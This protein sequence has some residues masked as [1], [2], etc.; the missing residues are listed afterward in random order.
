METPPFPVTFGIEL[1]LVLLPKTDVIRRTLEHDDEL[2]GLFN[3]CCREVHRERT[4]ETKA[5]AKE[6]AQFIA[7]FAEIVLRGT[8]IAVKWADS[9]AAKEANEVGKYYDWWTVVDEIAISVDE[10]KAEWSVEIVSLPFALADNW[11]SQI[12]AVWSFVAKNFTIVNDQRGSTHCHM[13]QVPLHKDQEAQTALAFARQ[14]SK[15]LVVWEPCLYVCAPIWR[16][17]RYFVKSNLVGSEP[18]WQYLQSSVGFRYREVFEMLDKFNT[19]EELGK[20]VSAA[21]EVSWN[22]RNLFEK[23]NTKEPTGTIEY[24]RCPMSASVQDI[25]ENI[26]INL[27]FVQA[28][29]VNGLESSLFGSMRAIK[30]VDPGKG[31]FR[32]SDDCP[33]GADAITFGTGRL[34]VFKKFM[35][36]S[37]TQLG[38]QQY[39]KLELGN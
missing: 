2:L 26:T 17:T 14:V 35:L 5:R 16:Q 23:R 15:F 20:F 7:E 22:F 33:L 19:V 38:L 29:L 36:E 27:S 25:Y 6:R 39:L 30:V 11:R 12:E 21:R 28:A 37:A 24:R 32:A 4:N 1:E 9:A 31:A 34:S 13:K 10:A 8:G 18:L 3:R